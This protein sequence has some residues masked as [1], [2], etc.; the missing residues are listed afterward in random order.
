MESTYIFYY[1]TIVI[2]ALLSI[3]LLWKTPYADQSNKL[4][5]PLIVL[6]IIAIYLFGMA[7]EDGVDYITYS[8]AYYEDSSVIPDP[9]F[10]L[11]MYLSN[12]VGLPFQGFVFS[13]GIVNL[14]IL[15]RLARYYDLSFV[16]LFSLYLAHLAIVRDFSQFRVGLAISIIYLSITFPKV[17]SRFPLYFLA[18]SIH[19][20]SILFSASFEYCKLIVSE[21]RRLRKL[22]YLSILLLF[23][24]LALSENYLSYLYFIDDRVEIYA[25]WDQ[26]NYGQEVTNFSILIFHILVLAIAFLK[27]VWR[28]N[29]EA[30]IVFYLQIL[31]I[32][33]FLTF[34]QYAIFAYRLSS[35]TLSLY[36]VMILY[37]MKGKFLGE[38]YVKVIIYILIAS[39]LLSRSES[40]D[41]LS[42]MSW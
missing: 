4:L 13:I 27:K 23:L 35:A 7:R 14:L 39:A 40:I 22:L 15:R 19:S 5:K 2:T 18:Y 1:Y 37:C 32:I 20:T 24:V 34:S 36:P 38:K 28:L 33:T 29:S 9:G 30:E 16:A 25:S 17:S 26:E 12:S 21:K 8:F 10:R 42:N 11:L 41:I 31:G 6:F 3:P